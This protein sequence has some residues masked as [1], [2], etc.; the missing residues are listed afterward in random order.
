MLALSNGMNVPQKL[1][2][3]ALDRA[4]LDDVLADPA[5]P[6]HM[7]AHLNLVSAPGADAWLHACPNKE[8]GLWMPSK[9]FRLA[10]ARRLRIQLVRDYS[11]CP[12]CGETLDAFMDHALVCQCCGDRTLRHNAVRDAFF[13]D[14]TVGVVRAERQKQGLFPPRPED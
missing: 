10:V 9:L 6:E 2:S 14:A 7:C 5:L 11:S 12:L 4:A 13:Q 8:K 1:L 3:R